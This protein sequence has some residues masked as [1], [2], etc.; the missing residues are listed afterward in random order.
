M[1]IMEA[2]ELLT[3]EEVRV[4]GLLSDLE[5]G[6]VVG[7]SGSEEHLMPVEEADSGA[8][9]AERELELGLLRSLEDELDSIERSRGRLREGRYGTCTTCGSDIGDERLRAVPTAAQCITHA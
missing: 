3:Q 4:R 9:L 7:H 8:E 6:G 1:D 5:S 2:A